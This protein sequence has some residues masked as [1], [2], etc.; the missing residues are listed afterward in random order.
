MLY[1]FVYSLYIFLFCVY[2][3]PRIWGNC[4][5]FVDR[6]FRGNRNLVKNS[7]RDVFANSM[8]VEAPCKWNNSRA[9]TKFCVVFCLGKGGEW[10]NKRILHVP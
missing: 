6:E 1:I 3:V 5:L 8:W 10:Q 2:P 7:P 9:L 4:F